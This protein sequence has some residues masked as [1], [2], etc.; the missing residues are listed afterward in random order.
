MRAVAILALT[1]TAALA[2]T[3]CGETR[4]SLGEECLRNED[5]LSGVCSAR[6]CV[7]A[8]PTGNGSGPPPPDETAQIPDADAATSDA[9]DDASATSD[10][11]GEDGG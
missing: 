3:S 6:V 10:D 4:Y 1:L 8:P 5:C 2:A 9:S 7:A 11:G